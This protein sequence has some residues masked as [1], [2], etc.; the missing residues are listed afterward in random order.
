MTQEER[1][2]YNKAYYEKNKEADRENN[3]AKSEA[4]RKNNPE[5]VI[6]NRKRWY[7]ENKE[8]VKAKVDKEYCAKRGREYRE[9]QK[10]GYHRV[11]LLEDYN[12]V[13]VTI[14]VNN[15]FSVHKSKFNRDCTNHRILYK[16]K[17]RKEAL[18]LEELLHDIGYEG[19][20]LT[21]HYR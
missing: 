8:K 2:A 4:Y 14:N 18:E 9:K 13:G 15:R 10:D 16:T 6:A 3:R 19:K 11:Y 12:Y 5:K 7:A 20:H 21:N 1:K 17:D